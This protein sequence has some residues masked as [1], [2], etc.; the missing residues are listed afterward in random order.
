MLVSIFYLI[1][2]GCKING[3][4]IKVQY[5]KRMKCMKLYFHYF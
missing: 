2:Y 5:L 3:F 1:D 4:A